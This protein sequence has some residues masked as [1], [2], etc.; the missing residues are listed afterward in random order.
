MK[1]KAN[2][3]AGAS[4]DTTD[5]R[6]VISVERPVRLLQ[7]RPLVVGVA[8][9]AGTAMLR[10]WQQVAEHRGVPHGARQA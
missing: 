2:L 1:T 3:R 6:A 5:A 7:S 4:N 9:P 10:H 8:P